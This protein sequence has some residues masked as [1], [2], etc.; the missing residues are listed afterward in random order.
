VF[1]TR[2]GLGFGVLDPLNSEL[3]SLLLFKK[4]LGAQKS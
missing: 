2:K 1:C 4:G 3:Q